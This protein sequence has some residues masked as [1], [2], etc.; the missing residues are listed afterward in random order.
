MTSAVCCGSCRSIHQCRRRCGLEPEAGIAPP[1]PASR[2]RRRLDIAATCAAILVLIG[3]PAL[4]L[5][6]AGAF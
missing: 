5:K 3:L 2:L 6:L 4:S 1:P